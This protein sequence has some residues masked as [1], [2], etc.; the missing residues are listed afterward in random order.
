MAINKQ[1]EIYIWGY[2][3][4]KTPEKLNFYSKAV[5]IHGKLILAEDGS[6]WN[7]SGNTP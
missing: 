4:S 3:Y 6:V 1:G 2:E 5:D 7:I